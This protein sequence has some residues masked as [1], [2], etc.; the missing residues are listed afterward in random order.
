MAA[1]IVSNGNRGLLSDN[2]VV[3][4]SMP[5]VPVPHTDEDYDWWK[6]EV[7]EDARRVFN[8]LLRF[9]SMGHKWATEL[10]EVLF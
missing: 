2:H 7:R 8:I 3:V 1:I 5:G 4:P 10:F 6:H 9:E